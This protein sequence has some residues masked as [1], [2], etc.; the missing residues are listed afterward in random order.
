MTTTAATLTLLNAQ[1][2]ERHRFAY[3]TQAGADRA[4]QRIARDLRQGAKTLILLD[5]DE[6]MP[7]C[8]LEARDLAYVRVIYHHHPPAPTP[9]PAPW[10][11][12]RARASG[13]RD[14]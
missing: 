14:D 11:D 4:A 10:V 2:I 3:H 8:R 9:A 13:E 12:H 1:G 7:P 5:D 6:S